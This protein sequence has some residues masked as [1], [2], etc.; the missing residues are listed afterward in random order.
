MDIWMASEEA[1]KKGYAKGYEDGKNGSVVYVNS[2]I[3]DK[4]TMEAKVE[5]SLNGT[6]YNVLLP[7][8]YG[9]WH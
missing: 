3:L 4:N 5:F 2:I 8:S 7:W 6:K 1:Y 9:D